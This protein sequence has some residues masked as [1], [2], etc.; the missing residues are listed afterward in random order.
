[1]NPMNHETGIFI[2]C[3]ID[4]MFPQTGVSMVKILEKLGLKPHYNSKQSCCGQLAFNAGYRDEAKC[5]AEKF[6]RDFAGYKTVVG[7]SASCISMVRNYYPGLFD[8]SSLHNENRQ[9]SKRIFE[10]TDFLVNQLGAEDL[11]STF[12]A[13]VTLHHSCAGLREYGLTNES[14]RLLKNVRG[15]ELI[16]MEHTDDCCGFGGTFAVKHEAIATAMAQQKIE[17]ALATGAEYIVSTEASCLMHLQGYI[18]RH[19]IPLKV[20]H[21]ADILA[22]NLNEKR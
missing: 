15:L 18:S 21:I 9:L 5:V 7:P 10:L 4:Q 12:N 17:Y 13:K 19:K 14:Q 22:R 8:N 11:G 20:M 2:P 3:F 6:I 16:E 1:M